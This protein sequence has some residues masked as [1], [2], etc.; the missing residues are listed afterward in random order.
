MNRLPLTPSQ[1]IGPFHHYALPWPDGGR[2]R[3]ETTSGTPVRLVIRVHDGQGA[4]VDDAL[5]EV[6]QAN[7]AG[8]Y[9]HPEDRRNLPLDPGFTGFGRAEA[10]SGAYVFD[11]V[12]PGRVPGAGGEPGA[13]SGLQ[14]PHVNVSVFARGLLDRVITRLYFADEAEANAEDP[15]LALVPAPRRATLLA[16]RDDA[17][18]MTYRFDIRLQGPDETVFFEI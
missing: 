8:R 16:H 15:V 7:A 12:K 10:T 9:A 11:T 17:E 5:V 3:D 6:W 13:N 2:M 1:T 4:V 14:A 18:P